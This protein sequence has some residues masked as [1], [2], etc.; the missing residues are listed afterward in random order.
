MPR[1]PISLPHPIEY[2]SILD[3][4]GT[5][6][7]DLEPLIEPA[8]LLKLHRA[9][10]LG[11]RF[12]ERMLSLQRQGRI[13]TFAPI[14]GQ[15]AAQLGA[16]AALRDSD[17]M[18]PSFRESAAEI[19]RGKPLENFIIFF[20]GFNEGGQIASE[21]ND[22]PLCVPVGSQVPH[23]V[24]LAWAMKYRGSDQVAMTFFGDGATSE[25]DFHE[26]L[27]LAAVF[28]APVIFV[29]QNNQWAISIPRANQTRSATLAQKA[30]AYGMPGIQVDGNDILA[31]YAAASE[32]VARA[33]AGDG[34]TLIECVTYRLSVHTTA[35]DPKR[36]RSDD[37][38]AVWK[39]RDPI[40][41]FQRYLTD[42]GVLTPEKIEALEA[43]IQAEIQ[44]AVTRAEEQMAQMDDPLEMFDHVYAEMTPDLQAQ[45]AELARELAAARKEDSHG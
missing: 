8:D 34:P 30:I 35:D 40:A 25:G 31:V 27:N 36:Y 45:Q 42:K 33:R 12:D 11:R 21:S 5:L 14:A 29:C 39:K 24:G 15:E 20:G 6:D 43:E 2:L 4:N 32:A 22:L 28:Q 44:A 41:R 23:A 10:L 3:E 16:V 19:W 17:W 9:M 37:D 13:G 26:G 1:K 18:V 38:V 7:G